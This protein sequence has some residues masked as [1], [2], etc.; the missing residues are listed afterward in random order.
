MEWHVELFFESEKPL[1]EDP[2]EDDKFVDLLE[3]LPG[4]GGGVEGPSVSHGP[5]SYT[6]AAAMEGTGPMDV[7]VR[8]GEAFHLALDKVQ[9]PILP[10][11]KV[12][13]TEWSRFERELEEPTY[14]PVVGIAEIAEQLGVSKQRVSTLAK[15]EQFPKPYAELASG[16]VWFA[17][18]VRHFVETWDRKPGRPGRATA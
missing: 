9:L 8:C 4:I 3:V 1:F 5:S 13:V 16:P 6:L 18:N 11:R 15:S 12:T 10:L 2:A 7:I 14:P 17:P